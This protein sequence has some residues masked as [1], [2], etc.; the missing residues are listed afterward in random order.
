[1]VK[2]WRG[3]AA[4]SGLPGEVSLAAGEG[5]PSPTRLRRR[6]PDAAGPRPERARRS[7][8]VR[9]AG[10]RVRV[11]ALAREEAPGAHGGVPPRWA[12]AGRLAAATFPPRPEP[13]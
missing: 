12:S 11:H 2:R 6:S 5:P 3:R 1:M 4:R 13:G 8:A 9:G 7:A 10:P